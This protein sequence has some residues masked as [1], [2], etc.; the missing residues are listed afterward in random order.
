MIIM[1]TNECSAKVSVWKERETDLLGECYLSKEKRGSTNEPGTA[2]REYDSEGEVDVNGSNPGWADAMTRVL[3]SKKPRKCRS[4]VLS[5]AK[6]LNEPAKTVKEEETAF[7]VGGIK[8]E[9]ASPEKHTRRKVS[10]S[11]CHIQIIRGIFGVLIAQEIAPFSP[12]PSHSGCNFLLL[13][14]QQ[15]LQCKFRVKPSILDRDREKRLSKIATRGVVQLFNAVRQQ[16]K[17]LES[18]LNEAGSSE[19][20]RDKVMKSLDKRAFLDILMGHSHSEPVDSSIKLEAEL[21]EEKSP[22]WH[23]LRDD[24]MTGTARLKDWDKINAPT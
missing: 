9:V 22:T 6:K 23:V 24:F 8:Q 10:N 17:S 21:K 12:S 16:Q 18:Q 14:Q 5:R 15:E 19:R 11:T 3:N 1:T 4:I 13:L 7:E 2:V 20:K